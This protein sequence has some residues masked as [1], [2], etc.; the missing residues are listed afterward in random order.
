[1]IICYI[2]QYPVGLAGI[3]SVMQFKVITT[4]K[5]WNSIADEWNTLL[6]HSACHLPFLRHEYLVN[7]WQTRGG[8]E[9]T[10]EDSHLEIITATRNGELI[11]IAPLF[12]WKN[13]NNES[14][15]MFIGSIEVSDYLDLIA[16]QD[17]LL[18]FIQGL[19][20]FINTNPVTKGKSLD[21]YNFSD[22]SLT[23]GFLREKALQSGWT[24]SEEA[25]Q[26]CPFIK[27]P[28]DWEEYLAGLDKKQRHEIRRKMRRADEAEGGTQI[29]IL[30]DMSSLDSDAA[31][32]IRMMT[33]DPEKLAFLTP[34]MR[35]YLSNLAMVA[36]TH[37]WL[38]LSFLTINGEKAAGYFSF[39]FENRLWIYNSAWNNNYSEYSPGWVLLGH[40]IQWAISQG[41]QEIDF[42][43]GDES[44][45]YKFGGINRYITRCMLGKV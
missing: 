25:L 17:D 26:P 44:Y 9:W 8:G 24:F 1:M 41:I 16:R 11:G 14:V 28:D 13:K 6:A 2:I 36:L 45:K 40:L 42:M 43:R 5:E 37:D 31:D 7:W 10:F 30:N 23:P 12:S 3:I 39:L 15:L 35:Q 34:L 18:E 19:L 20:V 22:C 21:L 38:N 4:E 33:N 29:Y 27:L 32:F